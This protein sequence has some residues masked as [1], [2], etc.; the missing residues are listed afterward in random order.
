MLAC[1]YAHRTRSPFSFSPFL[2]FAWIF[3]A[4]LGSPLFHFSIFINMCKFCGS[5]ER[6]SLHWNYQMVKKEMNIHTLFRLN[7]QP[8]QVRKIGISVI[9]KISQSFFFTHAHLVFPE[10]GKKNGFFSLPI[11]SIVSKSEN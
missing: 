11:L 8:K 5:C 1:P 6:S 4:I 9:W 2:N 3:S 10:M 7:I